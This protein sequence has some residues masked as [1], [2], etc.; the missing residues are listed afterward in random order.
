MAKSSG[1]TRSGIW[2][3]KQT[4]PVMPMARPTVSA[5]AAVSPV[6]MTVGT[7]SARNSPSR[8]RN[9][10]AAGL[11]GRR[12]RARSPVPGAAGDRQGAI[13]GV[14]ERVQL[15]HRR[16]IQRR[17]GGD[18]GRRAFHDA[19]LMTLCIL[20]LASARLLAGI[21][22]RERANRRQLMLR[23]SG[24]RRPADGDIDRIASIRRARERREG[25]HIVRRSSP[26]AKAEPWPH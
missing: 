18:C 8:R 13:A 23:W 22:W 9:W 2:P 14:G 11:A 19:N 4:L 5:V 26:H 25:Q 3:L 24:T 1:V 10:L 15:C 17:H 16:C 6:T 12:G 21:E 20:R 7:P